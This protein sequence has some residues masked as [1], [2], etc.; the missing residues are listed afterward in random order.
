[1]KININDLTL[2]AK[3]AISREEKEKGMM[4]KKFDETFNGM[5]FIMDTPR[6][7]FW[8]KNCII[9][10]DIIMIQDNVITKIHP[11]CP[12][13][14]AEPCKRYCGE[15]NLILELDGGTCDKHN[16]NEGDVINLN[17]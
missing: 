3:L 16:I 11:N 2:N 4:N 10:L 15:G 6:S 17:N 5:L 1:M 13:C 9:S 12:P 14:S 7:C 8:M